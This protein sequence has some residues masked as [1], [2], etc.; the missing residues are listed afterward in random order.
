MTAEAAIDPFNIA[1]NQSV[2]WMGSWIMPVGISLLISGAVI[3]LG[4]M[5]A[6]AIRN[7]EIKSW[8]RKELDE[9]IITCFIVVILT[10][11]LSSLYLISTA[12]AGGNMYDISIS[13]FGN[14]PTNGFDSWWKDLTRGT[15]NT[16]DQS[17]GLYYQALSSAMNIGSQ[18][19]TYELIGDIRYD[20][21]YL[22]RKAIQ[23]AGL[24]LTPVGRIITTQITAIMPEILIKPFGAADDLSSAL[25]GFASWAFF[26]ALISFGQIQLVRFFQAVGLQMILPI[27]IVLRSFPLT[28]KTGSTLIAI[29]IVGAVVYPL[30]IVASTSIYDQTHE[31]F[32]APPRNPGPQSTIVS[33]S[34]PET[35]SRIGLDDTIIWSVDQGATF[36]IWVSSGGESCPTC[37][38]A[39]CVVDDKPP[40][41]THVEYWKSGDS[42]FKC[43]K[44][45]PSSTVADNADDMQVE[46]TVAVLTEGRTDDLFS[47]VLDAYNA[48]GDRIGWAESKVIV[49]DPCR[50]SIFAKM[51]CLVGLKY[52]LKDVN[53][54]DSLWT[55]GFSAVGGVISTTGD[56]GISGYQDIQRLLISPV[57]ISRMYLNITDRIPSMMFP[58][59]MAILSLVI[60]AFM[61]LSIFRGLSEAI[62][63]E[64]ELPGLG[65]I[66]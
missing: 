1:F 15:G 5:V 28:R 29:A 55:A 54:E 60:S 18:S 43:H 30:S 38:G 22:L 47:F 56:L 11:M 53:R 51:K 62:G 20:L 46:V 7:S 36:N 45:F 41:V 2:Q 27:G 23:I 50:R 52:R 10:L 39:D 66:V 16:F 21:L 31:I 35:G 32:K 58:S 12:L 34:S 49:G 65:K 8:A 19:F 25:D 40:S 61:S 33:V 42:T 57:L 26:G 9:F 17:L 14:P 37:P 24:F 48:T 63:G 4:W 6:E 44:R 59:V 13:F 3:A 64:S